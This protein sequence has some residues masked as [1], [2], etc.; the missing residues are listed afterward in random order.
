MLSKTN[1][2]E[3]SLNF[4]ISK[5]V[6]RIFWIYLLFKSKLEEKKLEIWIFMQQ[7]EDDMT[8]VA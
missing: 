6:H 8:N 1:M 2:K 7:K 4:V 3:E 5:N